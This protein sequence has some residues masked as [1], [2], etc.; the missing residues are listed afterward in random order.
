MSGHQSLVKAYC[1]IADNLVREEK[2][3]AEAMVDACGI[4]FTVD[5][6]KTMVY[7]YEASFKKRIS[8]IDAITTREAA[9]ALLKKF[10]N[11][12]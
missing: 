2:G 10:F 5:N 1:S 12:E 4:P 9:I 7:F 3:K 11:E 8:N 6:F